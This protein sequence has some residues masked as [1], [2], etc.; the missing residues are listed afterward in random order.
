MAE[1]HLKKFS[2]SLVIGEMQIK[3]TLGFRLTQIK[4]AKIKKTKTE[5]TSGN[6]SCWK[7]CGERETLL[8]CW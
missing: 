8:H 5:K 2:T 6:S 7:G 4:M 1:K 3:T